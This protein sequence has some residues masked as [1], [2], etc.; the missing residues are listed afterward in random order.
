[1]IERFGLGAAS[2]V[3][4]VA[5]N[6]GYLLQLLRRARGAGA[7]H[8]AGGQRGGRGRGRGDP[9]RWCASS[10]ARRPSDLA[11]RRLRRPTCCSATTCSPTCPTSTTSSPASQRLLKPAG[12]HHHGVPAPR[13]G[14]SAGNQFDTIYHEHFSYFSL[15]AVERVFAAHGLALFDVEEL[16]THGGIAAHLRAARRRPARGRVSAAVGALRRARARRAALETAGRYAAFAERVRETKR[17]LLDFLIE[18][19]RAGQHGRRLRRAGQGQHAAQLLRRARPTSSTTRSIAARTSRGASCP[20]A[21]S[22]SSR[23][24]GSSRPAPT[25]C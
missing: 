4:E 8:R 23:P 17:E 11:A 15:L 7:R 21:A 1:M 2:Q 14:W 16:P 6:D 20:A 18:A 25:T 12:V 5:S 19:K 3:V 24:S 10:A 22:R 13:C 9:D